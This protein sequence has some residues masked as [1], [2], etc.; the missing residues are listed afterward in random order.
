MRSS[1]DGT[2]QSTYFFYRA[3]IFQLLATITRTTDRGRTLTVD[4]PSQVVLSA[5][6]TTKNG[7]GDP[8]RVLVLVKPATN[9][10]SSPAV[11][12]SRQF[13]AMNRIRIEGEQMYL[14]DT[15]SCNKLT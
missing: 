14:L 11:L 7:K 4:V 10:P 12:V 15:S 3:N 8:F 1:D 6:V 5:A 2:V 9:V 13:V